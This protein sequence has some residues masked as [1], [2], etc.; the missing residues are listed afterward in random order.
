MTSLEA[1]GF[2]LWGGR[3]Q[4]TRR[5]TGIV[6]SIHSMNLTTSFLRH[7]NQALK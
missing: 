4:P 1:Q 3:L 6:Y 5:Q 7:L 2:L